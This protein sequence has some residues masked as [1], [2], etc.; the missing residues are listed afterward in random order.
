MLKISQICEKNVKKLEKNVK[1][2]NNN[3]RN[4]FF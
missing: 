3:F 2:R 4:V 1:I